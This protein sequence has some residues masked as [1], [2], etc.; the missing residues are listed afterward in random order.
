MTF[1]SIEVTPLTGALG[2]QISGIDLAQPQSNQTWNEVH[3]AWLDYL[4]IYFRDQDITPR[5]QVELAHRFGKPAI[6]A[7][8]KGLPDQP[9]VT[10]IVKSEHDK[11][12]FGGR[13]HTDT[14]Y[15]EKPDKGT[16]LYALEV[17]ETGGDTLFSNMYL[18]YDAL[19]EGMKSMLDG[20]IA[21]NNSDK[22]Y[23]NG[24][25]SQLKKFHGMGDNYKDESKALEA[26]HP[27]VRTHP[28]TGRKAL[29]VNASHTLRFKDTTVE[30]SKPLIDY[31]STHAVRPEFSCR[32]HWYP[33]T[34]AVWDNRCTQHLAVNDY[35]SK[36]RRM[37]RVTIE[38][39]AVI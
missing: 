10:E 2:A 9:E 37:H 17:P 23:P 35:A 32:L 24:R 36:R 30:E 15:K 14:T 20:L 3:Q 4:M 34:L 27:V 39:E 29:Y 22:S 25:A 16:L 6:Y 21:V 18:A 28:E 19:S 31:L 8:I 1:K 38:G 11:K 33:G 5:Q 26:E 13:W 7:F 12:N